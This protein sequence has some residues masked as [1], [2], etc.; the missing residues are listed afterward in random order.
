MFARLL[1]LAAALGIAAAS[2]PNSCSGHGTCGAEDT[3]TCYQN[4]V[5]GDEEGGDCSD[6]KCPYQVSWAASPNKDGNVHTYA[7]CAGAG[8]CDRSTGD[9]EC[10]EGY[11]GKGCG[12]TT[13]P[14]DCSGHGTCDY[15]EDIA[16]G[17]VWGEYYDGTETVTYGVG[18]APVKLSPVPFWDAGKVRK[19]VCDAGYT[20]VDCSRR[21]CLRGNDILDERMNRDEANKN[22]IQTFRLVGAGEYGT[23]R[24]NKDNGDACQEADT[25]YANP[26]CFEDLLA[27]SFAITFTSKLNQSYTTIPININATEL[28]VAIDSAMV[29]LPNYV[30]DDVDVDCELKMIGSLWTGGSF[31]S[32]ECEIEFTGNAVMGPQNLIEI[33]ADMCAD[34]CTPQLAS[35]VVLKSAYN[36]SVA[37][38]ADESTEIF[39]Y[40]VESQMAD[41][42]SYECG[43]RGK[44][45]YSS[46]ECECFEGYT[47]D[48][49]HTQTALI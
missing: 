33:E 49:C 9:C 5:M 15:L 17:S 24:R 27:K 40:V 34:G 11:T 39:S 26:E 28:A 23:G 10:F 41:Y 19:C 25:H 6:R 14:N 32:L 12:I 31:P 37:S 46:G 8:I 44:C 42:N 43:R 13:C 7:E 36:T 16:F 22:Q 45:D 2:C 18:S 29:S 21:M 1:T 20:D 30:I 35:A 3:C 38:E 47:G 4:W 48:R